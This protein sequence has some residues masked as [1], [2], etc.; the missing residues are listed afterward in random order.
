MI[1]LLLYD[2]E[3][4]AAD[5]ERAINRLGQ[6]KVTRKNFKQSL[7][8]LYLVNH[9]WKNTF[10]QLGKMLIKSNEEKLMDDAELMDGDDLDSGPGRNFALGR[11]LPGFLDPEMEY[12]EYV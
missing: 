1:S 4:A 7:E 12:T 6:D 8:T 2:L 5:L 3:G 10:P 11:E 9:Q